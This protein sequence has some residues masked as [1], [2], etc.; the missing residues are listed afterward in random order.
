MRQDKVQTRVV[1]IQPITLFST[2]FDFKHT[3]LTHLLSIGTCVKERTDCDVQVEN[4]LDENIYRAK[5]I[6]ENSDN[7]TENTELWLHLNSVKEYLDKFDDGTK[8]IFG[9]S[10]F[11]ANYYLASVILAYVIRLRFPDSIIAVGGYHANLMKEDFKE[12]KIFEI[13]G[14]RDHLFD[15]IFLGESEWKFANIADKLSRK[16]RVSSKTIEIG[17]DKIVDL[18]KLPPIDYSLQKIKNKSITERD[19]SADFYYVPTFFSR[20][21]PFNCRFCGD[22]R[23]HQ[24]I[25]LKE[26][27]RSISPDR[28]IEETEKIV[29]QFPD[30]DKLQIQIF[31]PLF[32]Y[33]TWRVKY[34][35]DLVRNEFQYELWA[36]LRIYQFSLK[37]EPEFLKNL[38]FTAAFGVESGSSQ[39]LRIM[40]KTNNPEKHVRKF[41]K[42]LPVFAENE[43]YVIGNFIIGHP[44]ETVDTLSENF[45]YISRLSQNSEN[46][47]LNVSKYML[48]LGSYIYNHMASYEDVF[49][50]RFLYKDYW[51][52]P[53]CF[54]E[55]AVAVDPSKGLRFE[56]V[57]IEGGKTLPEQ[58][59]NSALSFKRYP[60]RSRAFQRYKSHLIYRDLPRWKKENLGNQG[61]RDLVSTESLFAKKQRI[62]KILKTYGRMQTSDKRITH[63][64]V[65]IVL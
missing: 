31:D 34:F 40:N 63:D 4:L 64:A 10:A 14:I 58:I 56:K 8:L 33:P 42:I 1:L 29:E 16:T 53:Y 43:A 17:P 45:Q 65:N 48:T 15:F 44:G 54:Y 6:D 23:N 5:Y 22:Y 59:R 46:L 2:M 12:R 3:A 49:G 19:D 27:W 37:R 50:S 32:N 9:I 41:K 24:A 47:I 20:G 39:M 21:C 25:F 26:K 7:E 60:G 38:K 30:P 18:A 13:F 62:Q 35:E 61:N 36:E 57:L 52:Y 11:S 51:Y 28:A 55:T